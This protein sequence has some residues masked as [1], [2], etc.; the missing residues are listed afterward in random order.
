[1]LDRKALSRLLFDHFCLCARPMPADHILERIAAVRTI[2]DVIA[3]DRDPA[4]AFWMAAPQMV[5]HLFGLAAFQAFRARH[6]VRQSFVFIHP[7]H[8]QIIPQLKSELQQQWKLGAERRETLTPRLI[9][10]LYGGYQWHPAYAAGCKY[11]SSLG[12]V[13]TILMLEEMNQQKMADLIAYKNESRK[14]LAPSVV[15]SKAE[16]GQDMNAVFN[17]FHC[18]D[19]IENARQLL[20]LG[21][22]DP[23][24]I[25]HD[26]TDYWRS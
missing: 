12:K 1:M 21:L 24:T 5:M 18:P 2:D 8:E 16:I 9:S 6:T 26:D 19:V 4:D 14:R 25:R 7:A 15:I 13:A 10:S 11:T 23:S 22:I 20:N 3:I 17:A